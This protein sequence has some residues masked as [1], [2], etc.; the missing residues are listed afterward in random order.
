MNKFQITEIKEVI[1]ETTN[2]VQNAI[3]TAS[4]PSEL[5]KGAIT[6]SKLK[7][8]LKKAETR[9]KEVLAEIRDWKKV[10]EKHEAQLKSKALELKKDV[11]KQSI[12]PATGEVKTIITNNLPKY[13]FGYQDGKTK[14]VVD[15]DAFG[16]LFGVVEESRYTNLCL[17]EF[18]IVW[19]GQN[20]DIYISPEDINELIKIGVLDLEIKIDKSKITPEIIKK[21]NIPTKEI[22]T[23]SQIKITEKVMM[24]KYNQ[25]ASNMN[26]KKAIE[27][28]EGKKIK[29]ITGEEA[30]DHAL[31]V[32]E[33]IDKKFEKEGKDETK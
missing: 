21:F 14:K 6:L 10:L 1:T 28:L 32:F 24:S 26:D 11:S 5:V 33:Y 20:D 27:F 2:T 25:I 13:C 3:E 12:N 8:V 16:E 4:K 23:P 18:S 7:T 9:P 29:W 31:N 30:K 19:N 15:I 17:R 22:H